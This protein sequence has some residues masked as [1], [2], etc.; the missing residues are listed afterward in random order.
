MPVAADAVGWHLVPAVTLATSSPQR[1]HEHIQRKRE[2]KVWV[3]APV[4][5]SALVATKG[6]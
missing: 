5:F 1:K 3:P 6:K 4:A 2:E